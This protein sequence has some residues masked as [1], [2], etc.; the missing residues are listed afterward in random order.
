MELEFALAIGLQPNARRT[1]PPVTEADGDGV[2]RSQE[3]LHHPDV[4]GST[5]RADVALELPFGL[6]SRAV[7]GLHGRVTR[8]LR[9]REL[10]WP[11]VGRE[12]E[13][14]LDRA[15]VI[16]PERAGRVDQ[17]EALH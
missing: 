6:Q 10:H 8:S 9:I 17:R 16:H 5:P 11:E 12:A 1:L 15:R 4:E 2:A 3:I 14:N 7:G 13:P